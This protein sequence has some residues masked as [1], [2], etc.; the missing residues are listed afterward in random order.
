MPF[1]MFLRYNFP[2]S[3][4]GLLVLLFLGGCGS[5]SG[6][7]LGDWTVRDELTLEKDLQVSK[8]ESYFFGSIQDLDVTTE[9][10]MV[11]LDDEANHLKVLRPDGTLIDTLGRAG[12]GPGEFQRPTNLTVARGDSIYVFDNQQNRLVVFSPPPSSELARSVTVTSAVGSASEIQILED[13]LIGRFTP[14]YTRKEGIRRPSP[15]PWRVL[16]ETGIPEDTLLTERRRKVATS[17]RDP[18]PVIAYLPYGR[19]TRAAPGPDER[20]YHGFTDSLQISAT[21]VDGT[22]ENIASIPANRVPVPNAERDSVLAEIPARIQGPIEAAFPET[23]PAFT[24]LIVADDGRLWIERPPRKAGAD[25]T[26]WWI[27]TPETKTIH[28]VRLPSEVGVR[29][30]QNGKAYGTTTSEAGAPAVVRYQI[31]QNT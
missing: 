17:F 8:T 11:V 2:L 15:D 4:L 5:E 1:S 9:G 20:L 13:V 7:D 31:E 24:D 26:S 25:T 23:K 14:G 29:V 6:T 12:R 3:V 27:L 10:R 28:V 22:T 16:R 18:G 21:S 19:V 30:V